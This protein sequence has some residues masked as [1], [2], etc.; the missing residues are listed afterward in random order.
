MSGRSHGSY[1]KG[2]PVTSGLVFFLSCFTLLVYAG[3]CI[4][5]PVSPPLDN[6][7]KPLTIAG[8]PGSG[9]YSTASHP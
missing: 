9:T 1:L 6:T 3:P 2:Y 4:F 5:Q 7:Q 8:P